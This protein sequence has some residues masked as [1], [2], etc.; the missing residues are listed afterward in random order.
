MKYAIFKEKKASTNFQKNRRHFSSST[1][2]EYFLDDDIIYFE[3]EELIDWENDDTEIKAFK[4]KNIIRKY[5]E[6][7]EYSSSAIINAIKNRFGISSQN[8]SDLLV[9]L[10]NSMINSGVARSSKS[11]GIV[12]GDISE[13]EM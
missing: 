7:G 10:Q 5:I 6:S 8:M 1:Y 11:G 2:A 12:L 13:R 9:V 4:L 3:D